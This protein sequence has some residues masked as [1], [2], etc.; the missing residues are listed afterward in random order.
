VIEIMAPGPLAT[1]QDR[2]RPGYAHLGVS[3]SGA[4][5]RGALDRANRLVGN[6]PAAAAVE[7]TFG[8][9]SVR[10]L[11]TVSVAFTGAEC[12]GAPGWNVAV[13]LP[14]GSH[15]TLGSPA[16]GLRSYL[17]VRGGIAV[18]PVLGSRS[19]D[20]LGGLGPPRL[21]PGDLLPIGSAAVGAVSGEVAAGPSFRPV[22]RVVAGPRAD[23]LRPSAWRRLTSRV[24]TVRPESSRAGVRLDGPRLK[25]AVTHELP[26]EPTLPG[27][28]QVPPDGQPILLGPDAPVT[29]GYPVLAV[30]LAADLDTAG[31]LR[32]GDE[33]RFT[34]A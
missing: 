19:T 14:A 8:G 13:T 24:W 32:S 12:P 20:T 33:M 2:G 3:R 10:L 27:A 23:W 28:V 1:V 9:L 30:V 34:A 5:D 11:R 25:R 15:L 29:G 26:S 18:P 17:A 4:A 16:A 21:R 6:D 31:Q 7:A 22:L